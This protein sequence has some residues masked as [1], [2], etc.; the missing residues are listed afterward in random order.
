MFNQLERLKMTTKFALCVL[1]V[2]MAVL[3]AE[4]WPRRG[5]GWRR[6]QHQPQNPPGSL[7]GTGYDVDSDPGALPEGEMPRPGGGR[8]GPP[9]HVSPEPMAVPTVPDQVAV[10]S[11]PDQVAV[12]TVPDQ[13]AVPTVPDQVAVPSVPDQVTVPSAP[14][15]VTVPSAQ[16]QVTVPSVPDQVA[17]PSVPHQ[18]AVP[19]VPHQV[20]VP[21]V[22]DQV[23]VQSVP[24]QVAVQSVPHQVAVQSAPDQVAVPI[25][26]MTGAVLSD[27][28]YPR[29]ALKY[30]KV[31]ALPTC[32]NFPKPI[33]MVLPTFSHRRSRFDLHDP[34]IVLKSSLRYVDRKLLLSKDVSIFDD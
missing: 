23:A 2:S 14:D 31:A 32:P 8:R 25:Y 34:V 11:V 10:P 29:A 21:T 13:V 6:P 28:K 18:V 12:P 22:P 16:D 26:Q 20:A 27:Q 30:P 33:S 7:D 9:P 5:G 4:A 3:S 19:T 1:L 17:V 24:H 15:Q